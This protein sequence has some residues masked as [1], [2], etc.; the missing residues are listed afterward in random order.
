MY[1]PQDRRKV[2]NGEFGLPIVAGVK[3][4]S[5]WSRA[6][7][8]T[9]ACFPGEVPSSKFSEALLV[10]VI[11]ASASGTLIRIEK[12]WSRNVRGKGKIVPVL[13]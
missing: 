7:P 4:R 10:T 6:L 9:R 1:L 2:E 11:C 12:C 5:I 13:N 8:K 3:I